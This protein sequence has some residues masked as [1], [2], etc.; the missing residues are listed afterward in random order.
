VFSES[1]TSENNMNNTPIADAKSAAAKFHLFFAGLVFAVLGA[2]IES[3]PTDRS[4]W[5]SLIEV[6]SWLLLLIAGITAI[7]YLEVVPSATISAADAERSRKTIQALENA[8]EEVITRRAVNAAEATA[9]LQELTNDWKE[10]ADVL[11]PIAANYER[12][13]STRY[14]LSKWSFILGMT[15]LTIARAA[16]TIVAMVSIFCPPRAL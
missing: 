13:A 10:R 2:A 16:P 4:A 7:G 15:L 5:I 12:S 11:L 9:Q 3:A 1:Q 14:W 8:K 6:A